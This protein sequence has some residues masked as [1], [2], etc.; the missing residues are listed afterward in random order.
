MNSNKFE[1]CGN[2]VLVYV[3]IDRLFFC[4]YARALLV[5]K[6]KGRAP[7]SVAMTV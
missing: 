7:S 2:A 6:N 5:N 4:P 3:A 1:K